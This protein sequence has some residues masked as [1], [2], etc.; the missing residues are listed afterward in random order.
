ML[1]IIGHTTFGLC[2]QYIMSFLL[3]MFFIL[4]GFLYKERDVISSVYHDFK[5]LLLPYCLFFVFVSTLDYIHYGIS[6]RRIYQNILQILWGSVIRINVLGHYVQGVGYLWFLPTLFICKNL[7]N[8][9]YKG[10]EKFNLKLFVLFTCVIICVC[11][12]VYIHHNFFPLPFAITTGM[13]A[14]G[15]Y[16]LGFFAKIAKSDINTI[17]NLKWYVKWGIVIIWLAFGKSAL[18]GMGTCE[19]SFVL[20]DYLIG[21]TGTMICFYLANIIRLKISIL[22]N[23]LAIYGQYTVSILIIH[24]FIMKCAYIAG[25][26]N[27]NILLLIL[28]LIISVLY[29]IVDYFVLKKCNLTLCGKFNKRIK[30]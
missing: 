29:V 30:N 9:I 25:V 3:P 13:N 2:Q 10:C 17:D 7:F 1:L 23:F 8:I 20:F 22:G 14:L 26:E 12:G 15:Y 28:N 27:K 6:I 24:Q 11:S 4:S 21:I 5:R 16:T 18:N 19:Y